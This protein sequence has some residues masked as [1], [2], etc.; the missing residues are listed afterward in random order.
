LP[1]VLR[2]L[3]LRALR[4]L[5]TRGHTPELESAVL[6]F[7]RTGEHGGLW[8]GLAATGFVLGAGHRLLYLRAAR[9]VV[10]T[11]VVNVVIKRFA[12]RSRPLLEGL[13]ALSPTMSTLSY[14][15]AHASTSFAGAHALTRAIGGGGKSKRSLPFYLVALAMSISRP[16]LGVHYPSDILA[17]ALLGVAIGRL[18]E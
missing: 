18:S 4:V 6:R 13:P 9:A 8:L 12:R 2:E 10:V 5:R 14:P 11:N 17:G 1:P 3:D 7:S 16:Y 15:S